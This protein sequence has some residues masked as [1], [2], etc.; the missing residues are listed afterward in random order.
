MNAAHS[1]SSNRH[2]SSSQ[3]PVLF[4][5]RAL[6][7]TEMRTSDERHISFPY[8]SGAVVPHKSAP[9]HCCSG[10]IDWTEFHFYSQSIVNLFSQQNKQ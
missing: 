6:T 8:V 3:S 5:S 4:C 10:V 2:N 9:H 7:R 1:L